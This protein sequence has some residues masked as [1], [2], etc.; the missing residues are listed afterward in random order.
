MTQSLAAYL[1]YTQLTDGDGQSTD[2]RIAT[3]VINRPDAANSFSGELLDQL[4]H[5]L[6]TIGKDPTVRLLLLQGE[7]K[8]FS[9]GADLHWMKE[10]A[11]L[12]YQDNLRE[13]DKLMQMF[14]ALSGLSIPTLALVKG[15]AFGGAVGLVAACDYAIGMEG[16]K[17][18]LS[19]AKIG[20]IPAVILPY[21]AR[22]MPAGFLHR[23]ALSAQIFTAHEAETHGLLQK[24]VS[25][26]NVETFV[27]QEVE[28][29][30]LASP[31]AQKAY[32][33]LHR[34]LAVHGFEQSQVTTEAIAQIRA[35]GM[36]QQG[37]KAFFQKVPPP[38]VRRLGKDAT[39][40]L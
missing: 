36:G 26:A 6:G 17:F 37:L 10:A 28:A 15:A 38:W 11:A 21:L 1:R 31:E 8:H 23:Q 12:D 18:C 35:S 3:L 25:P 7:G 40:V 30:L 29:L 14:E 16:A 39:L 32:K 24:V 13:A 5:L 2:E 33:S 22:K 19:E 34:S 27:R 4:T 20:L 9:A